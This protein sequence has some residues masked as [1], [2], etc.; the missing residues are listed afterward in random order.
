MG[1]VCDGRGRVKIPFNKMKYDGKHSMEY[2]GETV[3]GTVIYFCLL[4]KITNYNWPG[5]R[6]NCPLLFIHIFD[7]TQNTLFAS[8]LF[9]SALGPRGGLWPVLLMCKP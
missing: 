7:T 6:F 5:Q 1:V 4:R 3:S 9:K 8:F 2:N